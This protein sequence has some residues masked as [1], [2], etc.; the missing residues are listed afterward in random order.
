MR[1]VYGKCKILLAPSLWEEAYGRVATEAQFSGIPVVA[2]NRG[3]L[4]EAVGPGGILIAPDG[5]IGDWVSAI[6][7]LWHND[8]LYRKI[9]AAATAYSH[10]PEMS[11]PFLLD[12]MEQCFLASCNQET[13][14]CT[15][16]GEE[17]PVR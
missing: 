10:R 5:A 17:K 6:R 1:K 15:L 4:P 11:Y 7:E 2:S 8:A 14:A 9:S 3:G 16:A 13:P 12:A